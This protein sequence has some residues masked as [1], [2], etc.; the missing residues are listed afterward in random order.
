M[1]TRARQSPTGSRKKPKTAQAKKRS[2]EKHD[3][4]E[5][6]NATSSAKRTAGGELGDTVEVGVAPGSPHDG[7]DEGTQRR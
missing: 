3:V 4:V 6:P 2:A 1:R 7:E 5:A